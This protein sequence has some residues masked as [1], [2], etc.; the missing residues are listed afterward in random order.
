LIG[1]EVSA[2]G[3][4]LAGVDVHVPDAAA[5]PGL[6]RRLSAEADLVLLTAEAAEWV[7]KEDLRRA[8]AED[9]PL[10]LVIPDLRGRSRPPDLSAEL[11][12]QLGM[13]E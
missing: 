5:A 13:A 4:R 11:R 1:D 7:P 12:R 6:F 3:F 9:R 10:V 2:A 8:M